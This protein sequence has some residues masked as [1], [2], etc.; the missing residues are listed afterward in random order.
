MS[1]ALLSQ[2]ATHAHKLFPTLA[3]MHF[4]YIPLYAGKP[5]SKASLEPQ[6]PSLSDGSWNE[7]G[8]KWI[9]LLTILPKLPNETRLRCAIEHFPLNKA[10]PYSAISYTWQPTL[11]LQRIELNGAHMYIGFNLWT[12]L[13]KLE[14]FNKPRWLWADSICINQNSVPEKNYSGMCW[15]LVGFMAR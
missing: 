8:G 13:A 2:T 4:T 9:R 3:S 7:L 12:F 11:P 10:P 5:S 1:S 14:R 6:D 15:T